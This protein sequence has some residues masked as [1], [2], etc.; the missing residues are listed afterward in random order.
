[1]NIK[2]IHLTNF[3]SFKKSE[4]KNLRRVNYFGGQ[5]RAGK[6]SIADAISVALCGICR[7]IDG[8][9]SGTKGL[10]YTVDGSEP[11]AADGV[12]YAGPIQIDTTTILR[13]TGSNTGMAPTTSVA[14]TYVFPADVIEQP[15]V[16]PGIGN[17]WI[18][19]FRFHLASKN[20]KAG[21]RVADH[22]RL[23]LSRSIRIFHEIDV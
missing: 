19:F 18:G 4:V 6:S 14:H 10:R 17:H 16:I 11:T 1:M 7:G 3:R 9:G 23:S 5:N 21:Q 22:H 12:L 13:A 15:A 8:R 2:E 20:T